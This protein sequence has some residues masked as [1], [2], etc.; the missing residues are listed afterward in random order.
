MDP[1]MFLR[2]FAMDA[3][4]APYVGAWTMGESDLSSHSSGLVLD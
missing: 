3:G 2:T 4:E 1:E